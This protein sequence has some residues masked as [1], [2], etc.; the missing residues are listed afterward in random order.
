MSALRQRLVE[1]SWRGPALAMG[2]ALLFGASTPVAKLLLARL[3]PWYLA[4]VLYLGSGM[5]LAL[6]RF[7]GRLFRPGVRGQGTLARSDWPWLGG[8]ILFGGVLGPILLLTGLST[9]GAA[10]ASLL[11]NLESVFTALLAWFVFREN[12]DPRLA[13]GMTAIAAGAL[14][15]S[16]RG[17]GGA[18]WEA[19]GLSGALAITGA[20]F[21][22]ALD[23]NLT[24]KVSLADPVQIA[25][26]KGLVAGGVNFALALCFGAGHSFEPGLF[27]SGALLG[28]AVGMLGYG[29]SLVLFVLAL[30]NIGAARTG[31]Y[32]AAAPFIGAILAVLAF[33]EPLT[34]QLTLAGALMLAGLWLHLTERHE[35][36]HEHPL[37]AHAHRHRHDAHHQHRHGP[38]DPSGEPHLHR[39]IHIRLRHSHRHFPDAHHSHGH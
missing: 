19:G 11:L 34:A 22:W 14:V 32:F 20:C 2:A 15:L 5:G 1:A 38:D 17:R 26:L 27:E 7:A 36:E 29:L 13:L 3:D 6:A 28:A 30:R 39:H 18:D 12:V 4:A 33:G 10:P 25:M 23:N 8:A 9:T 31:A 35:H 21:A 16:W 37:L 24:R